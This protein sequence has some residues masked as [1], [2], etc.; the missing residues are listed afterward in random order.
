M[1]H[2]TAPYHLDKPNS[3][4]YYYFFFLDKLTSAAKAEIIKS[5]QTDSS[6]SQ[7]LQAAGLFFHT[8]AWFA[9][10]RPPLEHQHAQ[11][12]MRLKNE[13]QWD[14]DPEAQLQNHRVV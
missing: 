13:H 6:H 10:S 12:L 8:L 1:L 7:M 9:L 11:F 4:Y 2:G 14:G 3:Y 5:N